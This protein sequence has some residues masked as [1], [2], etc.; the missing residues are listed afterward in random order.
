MNRI[1]A[2]NGKRDIFLG[3]NK[4]IAV[5]EGLQ[6]LI[7]SVKS[8]IELQAGEAI[9]AVQRGVPTEM[10]VWDGNPRL[11]QFEFFARKQINAVSGVNK[12]T[13]FDAEV[14]GD[15][16]SYRAVIQTIYGEGIASGSL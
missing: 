12:I 6:A 14:D 9:Y 4:Q 8:A 13:E 15:V 16:L 3:P 10:T 5:N 7:Q 2:E 11:Q 1:F